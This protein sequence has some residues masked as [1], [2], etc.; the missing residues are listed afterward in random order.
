[1][2]I[3]PAQHAEAEAAIV[4]VLQAERD[5]E[6]ALAH[7]KADCAA[8]LAQARERAG[9]TA[10]RAE[11]RISALNRRIAAAIERRILD[12][13]AAVPAGTEN[14]DERDESAALHRAAEALAREL[15]GAAE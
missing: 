11:R 2:R 13:D 6:A 5:A 1:M 14:G 3:D 12:L 8:E 4:R 7:C 9:K 10:A 15:T